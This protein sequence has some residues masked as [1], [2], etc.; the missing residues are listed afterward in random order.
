MLVKFI[1]MG[2]VHEI[3]IYIYKSIIHISNVI[4]IQTFILGLYI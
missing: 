1:L 3:N 4:N 2:V